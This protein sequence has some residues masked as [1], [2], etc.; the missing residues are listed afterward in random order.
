M[1]AQPA[2]LATTLTLSAPISP[3][4]VSD[5]R[6]RTADVRTAPS[7]LIVLTGTRQ[8][9]ASHGQSSAA[10]S[11]GGGGITNGISP[12]ANSNS[13]SSGGAKQLP[14]PPPDTNGSD[15]PPTHLEELLRTQQDK[16]HQRTNI[17]RLVT[18]LSAL[19][20]ASPLDVSFGQLRDAKRKLEELRVT[21]DEVK[22]EEREIGIAISR[23]RRKEGEEEGL[24]VRRVLA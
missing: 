3:R 12:S 8:R 13:S 15:S 7:E 4:F 10:A 23:A 19:E 5:P 20:T 6:P 21:L 18:S 14:A 11:G 22:L 24:W 16:V 17:E 9:G 1:S 2:T